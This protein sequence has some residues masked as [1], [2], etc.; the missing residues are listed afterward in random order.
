MRGFI[1]FF[2]YHLILSRRSIRV[3][4][5]AGFRLTVRPTVFHPRFFISSERFAEFIGGL[6]LSGKHVVDIGTG[7]GIL[8]LAAARAGAARVT[9]TD[10]NPSA[11]LS[12]VENAHAN[13]LGDRVSALCTNLLS[14]L[15]PR[16]LF[17]VILSSPPKHAGR[18]RKIWRIAAGTPV[19][20]IATLP[21]YSIRRAKSGAIRADGYTLWSRPDSDLDLF[22]RLIDRAGFRARAESYEHCAAWS[23]R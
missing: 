7:S 5:A 16:P 17:D 10:I 3:T 13:G 20:S 23:S 11:A 8:A 15:A 19:R 14:A 12:A 1:H 18:A 2:S 21:L 6:D 9:A 4:H 22:G